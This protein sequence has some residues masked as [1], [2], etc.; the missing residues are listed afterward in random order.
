MREQKN[1]NVELVIFIKRAS[2][3]ALF[4][5]LK[6]LLKVVKNVELRYNEIE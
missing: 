2:N 5:D 4:F 3:D 1:L 6:S